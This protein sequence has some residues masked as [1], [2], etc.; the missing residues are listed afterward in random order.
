M[1][2]TARRAPLQ[3][4]TISG[5]QV[6]AVLMTA[7]DLAEQ[8][9]DMNDLALPRPYGPSSEFGRARGWWIDD[10]AGDNI[11]RVLTRGCVMTAEWW[12]GV[13]HDWILARWGCRRLERA[14]AE[15]THLRDETQRMRHLTEQARQRQR[16]EEYLAELARRGLAL[17]EDGYEVALKTTER[18]VPTFAEAFAA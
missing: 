7:A 16:H 15:I 3:A 6:I 18:H 10:T 4:L 5:E 2:P 13:E 8:A 11:G 17:D 12:D 1:T 9:T 14:A